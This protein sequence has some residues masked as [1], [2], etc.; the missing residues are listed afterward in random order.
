MGVNE[1]AV[2]ILLECIL[3][4][5]VCLFT[6]GW[7]GGVGVGV[8]R[9]L[10]ISGRRFLLEGSRYTGV[11]VGIQGAGMSKEVGIYLPP[12]ITDI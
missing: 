10:G 6:G 1:W 2:C 9:G 11:G 3:V 4:L 8:E 5:Q 12:P 7:G